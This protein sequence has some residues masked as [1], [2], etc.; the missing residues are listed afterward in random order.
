MRDIVRKAITTYHLK[1]SDE[2][3]LNK[4]RR[5]LTF[6]VEIDTIARRMGKLSRLNQAIWPSSSWAVRFPEV[7]QAAFRFEPVTLLQISRLAPLFYLQ[8]QFELVID[9]PALI[10]PS[11]HGFQHEPYT[12]AQRDYQQAL[13]ALLTREEYIQLDY[14]E[15]QEVVCELSFP[16]DNILFGPQV[17]VGYALFNDLPG[18]CPDEDEA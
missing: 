8:H 3:Y 17:T 1:R 12:T 5:P 11:L 7:I 10:R 13:I 16:P 4:C 9:D 6:E 18:L 15:M 14:V 2:L